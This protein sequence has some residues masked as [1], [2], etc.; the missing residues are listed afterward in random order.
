MRLA[1]LETAVHGG[2]LHYA[3]KLADALADRGHEVDLLTARDNA[4]LERRRS[5][6]TRAIL[7]RQ[8]GEQRGPD[9][10]A[11]CRA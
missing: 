7:A 4:L 3:A 5:A 10:T 9:R 11:L 8:L 2:L 6:R 1:V